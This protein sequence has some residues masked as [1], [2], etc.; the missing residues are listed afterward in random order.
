MSEEISEQNEECY[1][2]KDEYT[3]NVCAASRLP[4]LSPFLSSLQLSSHKYV[5]CV[6]FH[7][8]VSDFFLQGQQLILIKVHKLMINLMI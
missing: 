3:N 2:P 1:I 7:F 4:K 8:R 5:P 6:L